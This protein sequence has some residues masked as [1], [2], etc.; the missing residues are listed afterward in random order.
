MPD[1]QTTTP[2]TVFDPDMTP[3]ALQQ[4]ARRLLSLVPDLFR[5]WSRATGQPTNWVEWMINPEAQSPHFDPDNAR[6]LWLQ[7]YRDFLVWLRRDQNRSRI[8]GAVPSG[9]STIPA[10]MPVVPIGPEHPGWE[11][12]W[13]QLWEHATDDGYEEEYSKLAQ[14]LGGPERQGALHTYDVDIDVSLRVTVTVEARSEDDAYEEVEEGQ[15]DDAIR[16]FIATRSV[17]WEIQ[18]AEI[19]D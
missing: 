12:W 10:H 7:D 15:I 14:A 4:D 16:N 13:D 19:A 3:D 17:D 1:V 5:E 8:P 18:S 9:D 11:Q 6:D 2:V